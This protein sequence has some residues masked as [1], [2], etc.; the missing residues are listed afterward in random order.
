MRMESIVP[1][2]GIAPASAESISR[3][4]AGEAREISGHIAEVVSGGLPLEGGLAAIAEEYPSGRMGRALRRLVC[5][6]E[7]G[8]D[9]EKA[10]A[11]SGAPAYLPPLIRAGN[12]SGRTAEILDNFVAGSQVVS[13]LRQ[14]V[15]MVV[16]YPLAALCLLVPLGL[17]VVGWIV[18]EF[19]EIFHG[20]DVRLPWITEALILIS[21]FLTE[22]GMALLFGLAVLVGL[23]L[24]LLRMMNG[25]GAT[26]RIVYWIPVIG[27]LVRWMALARFSSLLSFLVEGRLPLDE[28]LLLAGDAS[29]DSAIYDDCR[30]L[31]TRLRMGQTLGAAVNESRRFPTAFVR[32]LGMER[33][34]EGLSEV[35]Q[36]IAEMYSG[37]ARS[38]AAIL[39]VSILPDLLVAFVAISVGLVIFALFLPL[40]DLLNK[41]S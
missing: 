8:S 27:R 40:I 18:P 4:S 3:L 34:P 7:R 29:G 26:R 15:W 41:L 2:P 20:F 5:E 39:L 30:A 36:S 37:R 13:D 19:A 1:S 12:R 11:A 21:R 28:A 24:L 9:L 38:L 31:A 32:A 17:L 23:P 35:L 22:H 6:L 25:A 10:L 14:T 33:D 16:A